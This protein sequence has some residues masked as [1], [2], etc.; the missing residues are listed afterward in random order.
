[1]DYSDHVAIQGHLAKYCILVDTAEPAA[2]AELFWDDARLEFGGEYEGKDAILACFEAWAKDMREPIE[3]LRHLLHI[4]HIEID[5]E[6]ATS[7]S[8]AD[9]DG[10]AKRSGK[11]IRNRA[12][13]VDVLEKRE[14][15]WKFRDRRIVWMRGLDGAAPPAGH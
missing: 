11:P 5:G 7:K 4:P 12:M 9:A 15:A 6:T 3:G 14:G 8:Y 2:I 10:H 13:Y 1:M